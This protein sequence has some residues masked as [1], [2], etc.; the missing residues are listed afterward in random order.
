[1]QAA[2]RI[3]HAVF[4][5]ADAR[6]SLHVAPQIVLGGLFRGH[7]EREVRRLPLRPDLVPVAISVRDPAGDVDVRRDHVRG[8]ALRVV[9]QQA[10]GHE[11]V[12]IVHVA[13]LQHAVMREHRAHLPGVVRERL[14]V[15][16]GVVDLRWRG[17]RFR[18]GRR[19]QR[20][21]PGTDLR[22]WGRG[23]KRFLVGHGRKQ[24]R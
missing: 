10:H 4:G 21:R 20:S 17:S 16:I 2:H 3:V 1:M 22:G 8:L 23:L 5:D 11:G 13:R 18:V 9:Q 15:G 19:G 6:V 7:L 12:G 14:A 24:T